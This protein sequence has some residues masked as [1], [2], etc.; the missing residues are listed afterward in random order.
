MNK[1]TTG[2]TNS[3]A[4]VLGILAAL[5]TAIFFRVLLL[6]NFWFFSVLG[7][8]VL[9]TGFGILHS[10]LWGKSS[11]AQIEEPHFP[12]KTVVWNSPQWEQ[13]PPAIQKR[14]SGNMF[15]HSEDLRTPEDP[16]PWN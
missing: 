3:Q 14:M 7:L 2:C 9:L 6:G 13:L 8:V 15:L 1:D 11:A 10:L 16:F 4:I 12:Q 5:A